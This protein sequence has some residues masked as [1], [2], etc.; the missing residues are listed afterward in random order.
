MCGFDWSD[1]EYGRRCWAT[2]G[3]V[4]ATALW[5]L[6]SMRCGRERIDPR[7]V[8]IPPH[9]EE[10]D[11]HYPVVRDL[12][13]SAVYAQRLRGFDLQSQT[14]VGGLDEPA[15]VVRHVGYP[16]AGRCLADHVFDGQLSVPPV[17]GDQLGR[18]R[19]VRRQ[20]LDDAA[21]VLYP[22]GAL[23]AQDV[24]CSVKRFSLLYP[25]P[26]W[27]SS[28]QKPSVKYILGL[29]YR[30]QVLGPP[31]TFRDALSGHGPRVPYS[32]VFQTPRQDVIR[33][34]PSVLADPYR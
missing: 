2:R 19:P 3:T 5:P 33:G 9:L 18:G 15:R 28:S 23:A 25:Q 26:V 22:A 32:S 20:R 8:S 24:G 4:A 12:V 6:S 10:P 16:A 31:A 13:G 34:C 30:D 11:M 29:S 27:L 1:Y 17:V 7:D 14:A 21:R